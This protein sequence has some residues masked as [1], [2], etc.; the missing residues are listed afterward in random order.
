MKIKTLQNL[1]ILLLFCLHSAAQDR[2]Q[3]SGQYKVPVGL[4][5]Y[6]MWDKLPLQRIGTRAYMRSTYDRTGGASDAS[7]FLFMNKED[8]NVT[9]DVKGKGILYFFRT[10]HWHGSPW[11]FKIDGTDNIVE[12][13]ATADPVHAKK[14]LKETTFIPNTSF[15]KPLAWTWGTT[16]GADLIWVPMAFQDSMRIAYSRTF[17]GTGYY[18]YHLYA[19]EENLSQPIRSWN[20]SKKPDWDVADLVNRSG[21]DIAPKN[22]STKQGTVKLK[23]Q[24]ITLAALKN[25]SSL[26]RALK[27]TLPLDKAIDLERIRLQITWDDAKYPSVDAPLCLFF[28]AGTFFNREKKEFLVKGLPLNIRYDYIH[29]KVELACYYPMPF[30][31]TAKFELTGIKPD[32]SE[33][34]YELRYE[35]LKT[36]ANS[37]ACFHATY[38]DMPKPKLGKDMTWLDTRG[39]EGHQQ[40]SGSFLGTSFIFSHTA[41]LHTLEGDPRFFF[42][43]SQSPQAYGTGTEEWAGGG[44]YWGGENMTLPL[45]GHPCGSTDKKTAVNDKDLIQSAYRFLI[46]DLMPFGNRAVINFEHSE[47]VSQEHYESVC[48]WYGVPSPSLI[49]TDSIDIGQLADERRHAY[50]SPEASNVEILRSRYE[51]GPDKFPSGAW[52]LDLIKRI[53]GY[54]EMIDKEIHPAHEEDGRRTLGSS[55]FTVKLSKDNIGALL[56]RTLDYSY[57]NQTAEVYIANASNQKVKEADWQKAGTWYLA[58]S[59]TCMFSRP[60]NE[61]AKRNYEVQTSNRRFRDDEFLIPAKLTKGLSAIR[62][63]VKFIPNAQTL[64]PGFPFPKQSAWSELK[65]DVYSYVAPEFKL[66]KDLVS[67]RVQLKNP[68]IA[69][70]FP[71]PTV[72]LFGK[73]YYAYATQGKSNIQAARSLDLQYWEVLPDVLPEKPNWANTHFW[74]PHVLFDPGLKKYVL[75]Y[76]GE[77]NDEQTGK[78][79]GVAYSDSPE[80][81]FIDKGSPLLCGAGFINIDP[82]AIIDPATKKKLLYW[83][84]DSKPLKVQEMSADWSSFLPGSKPKELIWANGEKNYTRLIEGAWLDI[85]RGQYYLYYSGD[86]C[87]GTNANY[88]LLVARSNHA[89]GPF[90]PMGHRLPVKSSVI[91]E[92]D[93]AWLAPGHNSIFKDKEGNKWIAYH[94]IKA[95]PADPKKVSGGR[96]MLIKRIYYKDGWPIVIDYAK[97]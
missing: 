71:D 29:N 84:S 31:K 76:S 54:K 88:A 34:S 44:D 36:P 10:N 62:I 41:N 65:Y 11:H 45:A 72:V 79:L 3:K 53:P 42:D 22:I 9:L 51:W 55:E 77:S 6:R 26:I 82:M 2:G 16:K 73:Y 87:C 74:A 5:A 93:S 25:P 20:L 49:K 21:T 1:I 19:N 86:N 7:H 90:E 52:G 70:D 15:P 97:K 48:Y 94:A 17:Y 69:A 67:A 50:H 43:D 4:D 59:N 92:K 47:N 81:P 57:P 63:K 12:E 61:L 89:L 33:I 96:Q 18:I 27:L 35:K 60:A 13:T 64:Y 38:K 68:V 32:D 39:I 30:F 85:D 80:G 28:G 24:S 37:N 46:A 23:Q 58:G 14:M 40:W 78:C 56:R 91:L 66:R 75:F 8:E 95:D 83:G